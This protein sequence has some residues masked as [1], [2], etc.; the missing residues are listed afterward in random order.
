MRT[1][2]KN[3]DRNDGGNYLSKIHYTTFKL[4]LECILLP[5]YTYYTTN[6]SVLH[7]HAIPFILIYLHTIPMLMLYSGTWR[8]Q[9]VIK[10][11][12]NEEEELSFF[13]FSCWCYI[14]YN[15]NN[16]NIQSS[17]PP[18][19]NKKWTSVSFIYGYGSKL[20]VTNSIQMKFACCC[21]QDRGLETGW[22]TI[23]CTRVV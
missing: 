19:R 2:K 14:V 11:L 17:P 16:N 21:C 18:H 22:N 7:L 8:W 13:L 1:W 3:Y 20:L 10:S 4:T 23:Y 5:I 6:N 9:F 12:Q 15:N